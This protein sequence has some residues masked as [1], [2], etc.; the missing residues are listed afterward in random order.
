MSNGVQMNNL[1]KVLTIGAACSACL[2]IPATLGAIGGSG[3]VAGVSLA[4][5]WVTL[6]VLLCVLVPA[7]II[8][9]LALYALRKRSA[10]V[11]ACAPDGSCGCADKQLTNGTRG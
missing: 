1:G 9:G 3:L 11:T 5:V 2:I 4:A 7:A 8:L 10:Q 6:D